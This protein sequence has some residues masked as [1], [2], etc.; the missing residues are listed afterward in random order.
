MQNQYITF[1]FSLFWQWNWLWPFYMQ[2]IKF[3]IS[4]GRLTVQKVKIIIM[5][6][7]QKYNEL[8][9]V[10]WSTINQLLLLT[11]QDCTFSPPQLNC[12]IL[13]LLHFSPF[14]KLMDLPKWNTYRYEYST[15][16][17][18]ITVFFSI[19][20]GSPLDIFLCCPYSLDYITLPVCEKSFAVSSLL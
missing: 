14:T 18:Y 13:A 10:L 4:T 8:D 9:Y 17:I 3:R 6:Y 20:W 15:F 2:Y 5:K 19:Q 7:F 1:I 12:T 16:W 11:V